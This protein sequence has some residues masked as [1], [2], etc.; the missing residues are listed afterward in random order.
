M[1]SPVPAPLRLAPLVLVLAI[2]SGCG[3]KGTPPDFAGS[4]RKVPAK[5]PTPATVTG[6][7]SGSKRASHVVGDRMANVAPVTTRVDVPQDPSPFRFAEVAKESGI[8]FVETSGMEA[9]TKHF[10]T[11]NGSGVAVFDYDGDGRMDLYFANGTYFPVGSR[12]TGPNRLYRNLGG[13]KFKDVTKESGLGF[14][15]YCHGII[16]ADIDNDGDQDVFLCNCGPNALYLNNGDGTFADISRKAGIARDGWSSGGA[17]IDYDNDGD[18]DIYVANYG[19]WKLPEDDEYCGD[20][21]LGVRLYCNPRSI[22][23][24]KHFFYRNNGDRT[25]TDVYD[26]VIIDPVTKSPRGR[27]DGHGFGVV[28][29]DINLDGLPDI[30]VANDMNPNFLFLNRGGGTFEDVTDQCGAGFDAHGQT[31]SGMGV[32]A[33]DVNGDGLPELFVTNF[34]NEADALYQNLG[35]VSFLDNT[36]FFGLA[37]DSLPY[38]KWGTGLCDFDSDGWPDCFVADGHVDDNRRKLDPPQDVDYEEPP[39][40]HRNVD[41]RRFKLSTRDVG[42]YFAGKHVGRG[43]A[44]GDLDDDGDVDIVVNHKDAPPAV[45]RNDTPRGDNTWVRLDLVGTRSNRDA[46]GTLIKVQVGPRAIWRQKKGGGSMMATND[47]RVLIG[48]G[49]AKAIDKITLRW[50]SGTEQVLENVKPGQAHKVVE[51]A[52][53]APPGGK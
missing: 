28:V 21:A 14:E 23:T 43:A 45:L 25:F 11:A 49:K 36:P 12:K 37:A 7:T 53:A 44:F 27:D 9:A 41:G 46:I 40:L 15:G 31:R 26:Q 30:Y 1:E 17:P 4:D 16:A 6:Q 51:P 33:E 48:L 34:A 50:P 52:P 20:K 32:D 22:K 10:P 8:D 47:G 24:V 42:P 19:R 5:A 29:A 38:V 2:V 3:T 39:L 18:L 35:K 13:G